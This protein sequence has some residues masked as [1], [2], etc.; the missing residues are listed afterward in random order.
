[1][2]TLAD[3]AYKAFLNGY[4]A[5]CNGYSILKNPFIN[6]KTELGILCH[7]KWLDGWNKASME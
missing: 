2:D 7:T 4:A 6:D 1:M 5:Y 3:Q